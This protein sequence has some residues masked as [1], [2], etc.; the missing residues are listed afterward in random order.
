MYKIIFINIK[1][2]LYWFGSIGRTGKWMRNYINEK[3]IQ[4]VVSLIVLLFCIAISLSQVVNLKNWNK[5][6]TNIFNFDLVLF[7]LYISS[8]ILILF[9]LF[10]INFIDFIVILKPYLNNNTTRLYIFTIFSSF[11]IIIIIIT[12]IYIYG[13]LNN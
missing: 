5:T 7:L 4:G 8:T 9:F 13:T 3:N 2:I 10:N 11:A 1:F 12:F 6:P